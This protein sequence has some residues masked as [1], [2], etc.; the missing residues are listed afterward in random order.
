MLDFLGMEWN[1]AYLWAVI[2]LIAI[3]VIYYV[4]VRKKSEEEPG[5]FPTGNPPRN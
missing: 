4:F 3:V 1:W 5:K 2:G